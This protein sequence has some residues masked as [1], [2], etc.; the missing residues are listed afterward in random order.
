[1]LKTD[2][3]LLPVKIVLHFQLSFAVSPTTGDCSFFLCNAKHRKLY[4]L[5]GR[6]ALSF[7]FHV[8]SVLTSDSGKKQAQNAVKTGSWDTGR[9]ILKLRVKW[10]LNSCLLFIFLNDKQRTKVVLQSNIEH[11]AKCE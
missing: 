10:I 2:D 4:P 6:S 3:V 7:E 1:M 8:L 11:G 5:E 9:Q